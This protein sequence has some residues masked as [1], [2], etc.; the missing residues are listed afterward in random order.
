M[1]WCDE[2]VRF[3][4]FSACTGPHLLEELHPVNLRWFAIRNLVV[5]KESLVNKNSLL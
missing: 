4:L 5:F 1:G 2:L 3:R